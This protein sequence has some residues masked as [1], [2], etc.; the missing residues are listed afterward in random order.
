MKLGAENKRTVYLVGLLMVGA[1]ISVY[2]NFFSDSSAPV[3]PKPAVTAER[4]RAADEAGGSVPAPQ[5]VSQTAVTAP[6]QLGS[7]RSRSDEF[8][9]TLRSKRKEE[10]IDTMSVDPTLRLDLLAKVQNVKLDG[11]QRNLFQFGK[12][13]QV[14]DLKGPEPKIVP[15]VRERMG[16]PEAPPPPPPPGPPP[17][18]PPP[19]ITMKYYGLATKRIDNKKTAF[20]LD[21][22]DI[23]LATEGMTVK[24]RYKIVRINA[25]S[26]VIEDTDVKREQTVKISEDAGGT[27]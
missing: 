21:G 6:R 7:G 5:P 8:H 26:V 4:N 27:E 20:F 11:G 2:V 23:I 25:E 22:E 16:P 1:A 24:R 18:V 15:K 3:T 9:P 12:P 10:Q 14:A 17:V 13:E 19:P